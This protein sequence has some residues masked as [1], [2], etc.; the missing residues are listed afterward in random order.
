MA[1]G[2]IGITVARD[3]NDLA[4]VFAVRS[5]AFLGEEKRTYD[6]HFDGNDFCGTHLIAY[7]GEEPAGCIRLR[8]FSDFVRFEKFAVSPRFRK[9]RVAFKLA[10]AAIDFGRAKGYR[11][12][13]GIARGEL[14]RFWRLFGAQ[15]EYVEHNMDFFGFR[16]EEI[17]AEFPPLNDALHIRSDPKKLFHIEGKWHEMGV[18]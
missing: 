15:V 7:C 11:R 6:G 3:F 17:S 2:Q 12:F 14:V 5:I 13:S 16:H 9:T 18:A 8:Y 10:R 1:G 4:K